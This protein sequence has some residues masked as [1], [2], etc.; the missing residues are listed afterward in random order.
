MLDNA[1]KRL[2][3][4][5]AMQLEEP[6]AATATPRRDP[7]VERAAASS[8]VSLPTNAI[9][10]TAADHVDQLPLSAAEEPSGPSKPASLPAPATV[11]VPAPVPSGVPAADLSAQKNR[12]LTRRSRS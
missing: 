10:Q 6:P 4:I 3:R 5:K 11:P 9:D 1:A 8:S 12:H 2:Q 7:S